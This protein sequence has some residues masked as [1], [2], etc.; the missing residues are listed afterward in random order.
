MKPQPIS[1]AGKSNGLSSDSIRFAD[2]IPVDYRFYYHISNL[3]E[4]AGCGEI[5]VV[6]PLTFCRL[7]L[8]ETYTDGSYS[9]VP[10]LDIDGGLHADLSAGTVYLDSGRRFVCDVERGPAVSA[11]LT[12]EFDAQYVRIL[13]H[14]ERPAVRV[15]INPTFRTL[16]PLPAL[17][18]YTTILCCDV[19]GLSYPVGTLG[20]VRC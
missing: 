13:M 7:N 15:E 11:A 1:I 16:L 2:N 19:N 3:S 8:I 4:A 10:L 18:G 12:G 14:G 9:R 20:V 6:T 17:G 5:P